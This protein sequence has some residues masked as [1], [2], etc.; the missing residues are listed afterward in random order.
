[1]ARIPVPKGEIV[2]FI[3]LKAEIRP[4][5]R[6]DWLAGIGQYTADVRAEPGNLSFD[7]YENL[8][9]PNQFVIVE[10]FKDSDAGGA[11]VAT[12]HAKKFFEFFPTVITEVPKIAYQEIDGW[13][14][15]AEVKPAN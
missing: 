14:D 10:G 4:E 12:D 13:S 9:T 6:D 8:D 1:M 5:K 15:M 3:V 2:I 11:H 7:C